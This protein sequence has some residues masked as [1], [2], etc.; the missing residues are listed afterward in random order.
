MPKK[1]Y[2]YEDEEFYSNIEKQFK[3]FTIPENKLN[4]KQICQPRKFK[5]QIPQRFIRQWINPKTPYKGVLIYHKIGAGKT[6]TAV[7]VGEGWKKKRTIVVLVPA[8]LIGNFRDELR[9]QC[10]GEEYLTNTERKALKQLLP[11]ENRYKKI[12]EKSDRRIDKYYKIYSYHKFVML[13]SK[14]PFKLEKSL[15]IIDEIQN[16]ISQSGSFYKTLLK[17]INNAP[18]DLRV[19]LLSATP[20]FD[21]PVEI[22]L[23]LNLLRPKEIIPTGTKFNQ[24]FLTR[25]KKGNYV[26]YGVKNMKYFRKLIRG[27]VSYFRGAPHQAFPEQ[28]FKIVNCKMEEFQYKTYLGALSSEEHYIRGSFTSTDILSLPN[29]FFIGP[30]MISNVAFPNKKTN[31]SGYNS[32]KGEPLLLK[33]LKNYSIKFYKILTKLKQSEGPVF[34]YSTFKEFGGI[35]SFVKV[36]QKH[37]YRNYKTWGTGKKRF[38]IWSGDEPHTMKEEIKKVF[39]QKDNHDGS[40]LR[41][42]LGSPSIKEGV[43]LLRVEQVHILEP[44]WNMSRMLQIIGR[45]IR[46]CSHKDLPAR[47]RYVDVF[48]YLA[49]YPDEKESVD[50]YIWKLAKKKDKLINKFEKAMK[51]TAIDCKLNMN[52]NYYKKNDDSPINCEI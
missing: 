47:R 42:L 32:F 31:S 48:L 50:K 29:N 44:Y 3:R 40:L 7:N 39:N 18:K 52:A 20:M 16:M 1:Y 5:L 33:N 13:A 43:S 19:V 46:Y 30:R 28:N 4:M 38:A 23:T 12:I 41:I 24:T 22:A 14:K 27:T 6:C 45:A 8:A 35:K 51:E 49:Y 15:L 2:D 26:T 36:L 37:G 10:A 17:T 11:S 25:K 21:K 9:S 34:V